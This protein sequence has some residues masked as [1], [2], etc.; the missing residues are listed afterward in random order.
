MSHSR[1]RCGTYYRDDQALC[2]LTSGDKVHPIDPVNDGNG[3]FPGYVENYTKWTI[4]L[5]DASPTRFLAV[6]STSFSGTTGK[7]LV[8]G[9][10]R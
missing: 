1:N 9:C 2:S 7:F 4:N 3:T 6:L 5:A 10:G 8:F